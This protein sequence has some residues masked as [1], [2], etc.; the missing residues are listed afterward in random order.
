MGHK[1]R[2]RYSKRV[3]DTSSCQDGPIPE[4]SDDPIGLNSAELAMMDHW[5]AVLYTRDEPDVRDA[6]AWN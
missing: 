4:V 6:L 3:R 2:P 5:A 1:T